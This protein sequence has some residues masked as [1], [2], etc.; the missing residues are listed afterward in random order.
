MR[1]HL[2][3]KSLTT[4]ATTPVL[5]RMQFVYN[6]YCDVVGGLSIFSSPGA[7]GLNGGVI[8]RIDR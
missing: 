1:D 6:G 4:G 8:G 7:C 2:E 3:C 5:V